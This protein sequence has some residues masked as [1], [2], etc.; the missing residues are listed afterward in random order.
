MTT[1]DSASGI[2]D[3]RDGAGRHLQCRFGVD[4]YSCT[5][6]SQMNN[7]TFNLGCTTFIRTCAQAVVRDDGALLGETLHVR[8]LFAE[9]GQRDEEWEIP[10]S[11]RVSGSNVMQACCGLHIGVAHCTQACIQRCTYVVPQRTRVGPQNVTALLRL[12][13]GGLIKRQAHCTKQ[14]EPLLATF[15]PSHRSR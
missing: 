6:A 15:Q 12:S 11:N 8:G 5:L 1:C 14:F 7:S 2:G 3:T 4:F 13:L 9:E 10:E